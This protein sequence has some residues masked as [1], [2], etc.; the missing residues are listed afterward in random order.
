MDDLLANIW[1]EASSERLVAFGRLGDRSRAQFR[2]DVHRFAQRILDVT[3]P[4]TSLLMAFR[5]DRYAFAVALIAAWT[6]GVPVALP[7]NARRETIGEMLLDPTIGAMA[8]DLESSAGLAMRAWFKATENDPL[9]LGQDDLRG[10]AFAD[11][12]RRFAAGAAEH[13]ASEHNT[14]TA[15]AIVATLYSSGTTGAGSNAAPKTAQQLLGEARSLIPLV[16]SEQARIVATVQ[17]AHIYGLLYSVL[18]PLLSGGSFLRETPLF[19]ATVAEAVREHQ[20]DVLVTVPAHL[21]TF[22]SV[23]VEDFRSL[24][25]VVCSTAPLRSESAHAFAQRFERPII[26]VLGSSETGGMAWRESSADTYWRALPGIGLS[27]NE[28]GHLVVTS[29]FLHPAEAQPYVSA[30]LVRFHGETFEHLGRADGVVKIGG[31]RVALRDMEAR[32]L[33]LPGVD[34]AAVLAIDTE[35]LRGTRLMLAVVATGQTKESL[36]AALSE[37]YD[38]SCLPRRVEFVDVLPREDNGKLPRTRL[39]ALF[40]L[41]AT[42]EPLVWDLHW[43]KSW[44]GEEASDGVLDHHFVIDVPTSYGWFE[45]HFQGYPVMAAAVQL[46]ELLGPALRSALG[47]GWVRQ[48]SRMKFTG[49]ISPGDKVELRL[50]GERFSPSFSIWRDGVLCSAGAVEWEALS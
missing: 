34:D 8:H 27:A 2:R 14:P 23:A 46:H 21:A 16:T 39:L 17:P 20:A 50:Q 13:S 35:G 33:A 25:R 26:E 1:R 44:T 11:V 41:N 22:A 12:R 18:V 4:N 15:D 47:E 19:P 45:G 49:R 48:V 36:L 28:A 24:V 29:P 37:H 43:A 9:E 40:H 7:P 31:R 32:I 3:P 30:D 6:V 38:P 42:G 5:E 10:E